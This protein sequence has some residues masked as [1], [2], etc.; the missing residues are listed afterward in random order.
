MSHPVAGIKPALAYRALT[1]LYDRVVAMTTRERRFKSAL[2][3]QA[4]LQPGQHVLDI[5]A[6]TGTLALLASER[7]PDLRVIGIDA[8]PD[9]LALPRRKADVAGHGVRFELGLSTTLPYSDDSFDRVLSSLF[10]HHLLPADKI[11]TAKEMLRVL[12]PGGDVPRTRGRLTPTASSHA[13]TRNDHPEPPGAGRAHG[14][15]RSRR[16]HAVKAAH[17]SSH[18]HTWWVELSRAATRDEVLEA[19]RAA[20]RIAFVRSSDGIVALNSTV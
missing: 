10:F 3:E 19:F 20:P 17:N 16:C 7:G 18:L 4:R 11:T 13:C 5:G 1:P 14:D 8:D 12:R 9:V 6:G 15:P 2:L